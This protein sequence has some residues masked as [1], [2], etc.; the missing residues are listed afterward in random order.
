MTAMSRGRRCA[1]GAALKA[2]RAGDAVAP[3]WFMQFTITGWNLDDLES[4]TRLGFSLQ[5]AVDVWCFPTAAQE[6][7]HDGPHA[8]TM[9][10]NTPVTIEGSK[11][12]SLMGSI[13]LKKLRRQAKDGDEI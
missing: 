2:R 6:G 5:K 13:V 8:V 9:V 7:S 12:W 3:R 1:K 4:G 10:I 11:A